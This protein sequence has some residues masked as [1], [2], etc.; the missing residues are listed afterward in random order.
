MILLIVA[1]AAIVIGLVRGGR[2]EG[3]SSVPFR[4]GLAVLILF[5]VQA[6]VRQ[7]IP[8]LG[9]LSTGVLVLSWVVVSACLLVLCA[10]NWRTVG[11]RLLALGIALNIVVVA[12]NIGMPV[13]GP[14]AARLGMAPSAESIANRGAFY[15]PVDSGT[16]APLLGDVIPIPAPQPLRSLVSMGD[17]LMFLAVG[18]LIEETIRRARYRPRHSVGSHES[19][20]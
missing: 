13:G 10:L 2:I 3:L 1:L 6:V 19:L 14:L 18:V 15:Q 5:V 8:E 20:T 17:V 9:I 7:F 4:G 16:V 12:L 11:V